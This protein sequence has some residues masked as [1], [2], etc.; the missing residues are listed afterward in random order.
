MSIHVFKEDETKDKTWV[1][2]YCET[3]QQYQDTRRITKV[4]GT[5]ILSLGQ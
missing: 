1:C 5:R 3:F 2:M 4:Q